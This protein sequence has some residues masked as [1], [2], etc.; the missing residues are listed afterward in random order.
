MLNDSSVWLAQ[1]HDWIHA[2][3]ERQ[4]IQV[5]GAIEQPHVRPWSHVLRV[6]TT[7]GDIFFKAVAPELHHEV[8]LTTTLARWYPDWMVPLLAADTRRGW[9]LMPDG[10]TRLREIIWS[11]HDLRHWQDVLPRYAELQC[12]VAGHA[13]ELLALGVPDRRLDTLPEQYESLLEQRD[14]FSINL[15]DG[16]PADAY[17]QLRDLIPH[18][19]ALCAEL[20]SYNLPASLHHG[21]LHDGN[22]FMRDGNFRFFDWGDASITHPFFSLRTMFVSVEMSLGLD[23]GVEPEQLLDAYLEPWT[24]YEPRANLEKIYGLARRLSPLCSALAW[25]RVVSTLDASLKAEYAAPVPGLLL[26]FL[27]LAT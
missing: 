14:A 12:D 18:V 22:I 3:L 9:M 1:A 4:G 23:E 27:Q 7:T 26:E 8:A 10:G 17:Q 15:Q 20:S 2:E 25:H 11:D 24:S 19:A 6:P 5:N 13:D 21:D 16:L